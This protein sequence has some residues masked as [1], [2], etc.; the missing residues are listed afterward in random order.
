MEPIVTLIV[1]DDP[2]VGRILQ[3]VVGTTPGFRVLGRAETLA[4]AGLMLTA[5]MPEL[6]LVDLS[7]PDGS[8]LDWLEEQRRAG[9]NA[10]II[11]ITAADDVA[12]VQRAL[13]TG[14][15]DYIIKPLRLARIQQSLADLRAFH[16]R[17]R[18]PSSLDQGTLDQ[19]LGKHRPGGEPQR[20]TPKGIDA[21]TLRQVEQLFESAPDEGFSADAVAQRLSMSRTTARRYLEYLESE[22]RLR[23]SLHYGSRG[24]PERIYRRQP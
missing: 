17:L 13:N 15:F 23:I 5:G 24:R 14:V 4:E 2:R 12:T 1:E 20:S 8:G 16:T 9:L 18:Q 6:L 7:L 10:G 22:D 19:M 3:E 11:M 21:L